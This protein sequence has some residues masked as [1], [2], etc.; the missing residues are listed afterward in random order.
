M[1]GRAGRV[2][3]AARSF[4]LRQNNDLRIVAGFEETTSGDI[5]L[6][7]KRINHL[8]AYERNVST[9]FQSYALFRT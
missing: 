3:C 5:L 7:G 6:A 4:G 2:L 8:R 9:V 1:S